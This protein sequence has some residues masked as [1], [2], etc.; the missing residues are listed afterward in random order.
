MFCWLKQW[1][2]SSALD[3]R[4][5][6]PASLR[7]HTE[8]CDRCA[9]FLA[10]SRR[11]ADQLRSEAATP[12]AEPQIIR[13][14]LWRRA[15]PAVAAAAALVA[16]AAGISVWRGGPD[17]PRPDPAT[18]AAPRRQSPG[19]PD[20]FRAAGLANQSLAMIERSSTEPVREELQGLSK[21]AEAAV[22]T[23]LSYLPRA[24]QRSDN[25]R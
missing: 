24:R 19:M 22:S 20:P 10:G 8:R 18:I 1:R 5:A 4:R 15:V 6:L 16:I 25:P 21:D 23:L 9:A 7:G 11:L 14:P 3:D 17:T 2:I 12:A 13:L